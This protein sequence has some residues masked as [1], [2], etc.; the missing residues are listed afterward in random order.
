MRRREHQGRHRHGLR[1][2]QD[3]SR[4]GCA[5]HGAAGMAGAVRFYEVARYALD[6]FSIATHDRC[7]RTS[8]KARARQADPEFP[9]RRRSRGDAAQELHR[10]RAWDPGRSV[11]SARRPGVRQPARVPLDAQHAHRGDGTHGRSPPS[12]MPQPRRRTGHRSR[13][14]QADPRLLPVCSVPLQDIERAAPHARQAIED[15][16]AALL[17]P[18]RMPKD[19]A[20][21]HVGF[22]PV[23]AA[24]QEA[25][26]PVV[27]HVATPDLVMPPQHRNN[28]LPPEPDFHGGG[29]NFRSV[30]YMVDLGCTAAGAVD[31]DLRRRARALSGAED[32]RDRAGRCVG[33]GLHAP[34]RSCVRRVRAARAAARQAQ[35]AP[36]GVR[37]P[38]SAGHALPH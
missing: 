10:T 33:A 6:H 31:A 5:H 26:I 19:H 17:I 8:R 24:A 23:W 20:Q 12:P 38:P 9:R 27:M 29:E 25:G 32:R 3:H 13:S 36:L 14:A 4:R 30:S 2:G 35:P 7:S 11:P 18:N 37:P 28:G 34:A 16:A 22:D 15:G 21:S 1:R